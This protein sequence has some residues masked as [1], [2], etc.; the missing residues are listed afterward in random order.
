MGK[1]PLGGDANMAPGKSVGVTQV[2]IITFIALIL[3]LLTV[4]LT[5]LINRLAYRPPCTFSRHVYF[6]F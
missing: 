2:L 1:M 5:L 6:A 4:T 3:T